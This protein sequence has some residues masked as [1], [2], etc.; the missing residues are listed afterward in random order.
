MNPDWGPSNSA[1]HSPHPQPKAPTTGP[2]HE[3]RLPLPLALW[4]LLVA[5]NFN[6]IKATENP[7]SRESSI[8]AI[9]DSSLAID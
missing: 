2:I 3:L 9:N 8:K 4:L 1:F 7:G 5:Y 6:L